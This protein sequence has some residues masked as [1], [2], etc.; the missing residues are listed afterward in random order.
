M[1]SEACPLIRKLHPRQC[2]RIFMRMSSLPK[3]R[4]PMPAHSLVMM[5]R[6]LQPESLAFIMTGLSVCFGF[7]DLF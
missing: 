3:I 4:R 7:V 1:L 2:C 6:R 5:T